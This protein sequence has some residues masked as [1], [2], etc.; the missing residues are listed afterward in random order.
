MVRIFPP[1]LLQAQREWTRTYEALAHQPFRTVLR[2]RLQLLSSRIARHSYWSAKGGRPSSDRTELR[3][4]A[5]AAEQDEKRPAHG[6]TPGDPAVHH[7]F[8]GR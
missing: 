2:R 3:R 7:L 8:S 5:R 1:D 4:Q 6:R